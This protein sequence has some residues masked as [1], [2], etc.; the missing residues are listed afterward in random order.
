MVH[1][2]CRLDGVVVVV[3]VVVCEIYQVEDATVNTLSPVMPVVVY[4]VLRDTG[5]LSS[6][7]GGAIISSP[8]SVYEGIGHFCTSRVYTIISTLALVDALPL[9]AQK[10]QSEHYLNA[11]HAVNYVS[12]PPAL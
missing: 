7:R 9:S 10:I 8:T 3:V 12:Q 4:V 11:G 2:D 5:L 1:F 6:T